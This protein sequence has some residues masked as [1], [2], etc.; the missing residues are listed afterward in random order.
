VPITYAVLHRT[1]YAYTSPVR[2]G[3]HRLMLRPRDSHEVRLLTTSLS[4]R[5]EPAAT[6]WLFDVYGNSIAVVAFDEEAAS[7]LVIE[8]RLELEHHGIVQAELPIEPFARTWPFNYSP[9]EMPDLAPYLARQWADQ[10]GVLD[11]WV[12]RLVLGREE[13]AT[14]ELLVSLSH[15]IKETLPY[16]VRYEEGTQAPLAT[17]RSGGSCRDFAALMMEALRALGIA[18]R[19]VS[20]YLYSPEADPANGRSPLIGGGATHAWVDVFL[21]GAG[22]VEFDPTNA[23]FGGTDLIRVAVARAAELA[24]PVAGTFAG[25]VGANL[26]VEVTVTVERR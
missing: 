9:H 18:A 1:R 19:F 16:Q 13:I 14:Q 10:E 22:W 11:R 3:P 2:L 17:L 5:P 15:R 23:L 4:I 6:H 25:P 20:G 8:S 21:P 26:P 7:E 12:R 24:V